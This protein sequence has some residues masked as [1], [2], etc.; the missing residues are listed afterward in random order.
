M[1]Y[2]LFFT[3]TPPPTLKE[4]MAWFGTRHH[5]QMAKNQ[6]FRKSP[7]SGVYWAFDF[8]DE[9]GARVPVSF[10]LNYFRPD[11]FALEA[12]D[13]VAAFVE[14]FGLQVDDPQTDGMGQGPFSREGFLRGWRAGNRFTHDT[15][16]RQHPDYVV[17][18]KPAAENRAVAAW[19]RFRESYVEWMQGVEDKG[20]FVPTV[21]YLQPEDAPGT[22]LTGAMWS[23]ATACAL[24]EVDLIIAMNAGEEGPRAIPLDDLRNLLLPFEHRP[25]GHT[26]TLGEVAHDCGLAHWVVDYP[27]PP[28][29]LVAALKGLGKV[30]HFERIEPDLVLDAE[31]RE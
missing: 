27:E 16:T 25:A 2:D 24:P 13:E 9:D 8:S 20:G 29:E 28:V 12:A 21:M 11:V 4:L 7:D 1:S 3:K 10:N 23:E 31:L 17:L 26:I 15:I 22:V 14:A 5:Y 19:N 18:Y 30:R 6:A